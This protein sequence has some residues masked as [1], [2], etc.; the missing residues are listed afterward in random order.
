[1]LLLG[2]KRR[3]GREATPQHPSRFGRERMSTAFDRVSS[4]FSVGGL[5][6]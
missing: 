3:Q 1:L 4:L 2:G 5:C 6:A